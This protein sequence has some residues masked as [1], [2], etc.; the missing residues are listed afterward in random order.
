MGVWVMAL[1]VILAACSNN[2]S[3]TPFVAPSEAPAVASPTSEAP[4]TDAPAGWTRVEGEGFSMTLPEGWRAMAPSDINDSGIFE[5][6]RE[7]NPNAAGAID[8]AEAAL[9]SG[10]ISF[11]AFDPGERTAQTGFAT[12]VN[13]IALEDVGGT[14][15]EE[16][17]EELAGG[18]EQ[19]TPRERIE[20]STITLPGGEAGVVRY[21]WTLELPNGGSTELAGTQYIIFDGDRAFVITLTGIEEFAAEDA[22]RWDQ[23][24]ESFRVEE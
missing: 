3:P 12:N 4:S 13:V 2:P 11:F 23:V 5:Q 20:T 7:A 9:A 15:V 8:Q 10:Q 1:A 24:A 22:P 19:V 16:A 21:V 14:S 17:T 18:I 6:L